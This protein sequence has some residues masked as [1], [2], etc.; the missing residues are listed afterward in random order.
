MP[1]RTSATLE[2]LGSDVMR[3]TALVLVVLGMVAG[4]S[5][6]QKLNPWGAKGPIVVGLRAVPPET[7]EVHTPPVGAE[8]TAAIGT[9]MVA[10]ATVTQKRAVRILEP[11]VASDTYDKDYVRQ[12][13]LPP[14]VYVVAARD[15]DGNDY[16]GVNPAEIRWV[17]RGTVSQRDDL[18]CDLK[19]T[20]LG[21]ASFMWSYRGKR[22]FSEMPAPGVK[23]E[24]A[25]GPPIEAAD[26]F[27]RELV[28]TGRSGT[29]VSLMYR[30][31]MRDMARPAFSQDLR[32]DIANDPVI[33]YQ[34]ARF[35][36]LKA[37]NT[38]ITYQ[39]IEPLPLR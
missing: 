11:L 14:G 10:R 30:E 3:R 27:R 5:T 9:S 28:Y 24:Q 19:L 39:V 2:A 31:F 13:E 17:Y 15:A 34:G 36:V 32:Y 8:A 22:Q 35:K 21:V 4:C 38:A 16:F 12:I 33:G 18:D 23:F 29:T 25:M 20:P 26:S 37:D 7:T 1:R 6:V